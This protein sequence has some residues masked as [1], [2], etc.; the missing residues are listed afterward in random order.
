MV[1]FTT[2]WAAWTSPS[3]RA[4]SDTT[5]VPGWSGSA[6]TLPRTTPSTRRPPLKN[7]LPSMR[8]VAPIRLSMRFCG[9]LS[10][11]NMVLAPLLPSVRSSLHRRVLDHLRLRRT[12]F[13]NA[14]LHARY[15]CLR[16]HPENSVNPLEVLEPQPE[17][18]R[19]GILGSRHRDHSTAAV[20]R[21]AD[22]QFQAP[23]ELLAA[24]R[25]GG[26]QHHPVAVFPWQ[27]VGFYLEAQDGKRRRARGLRGQHAFE[28][29]ELFAQARVFL[30]HGL[31]LLRELELRAALD[32]N[33]AVG[34]IGHRAQAAQFFAQLDEFAA[35]SVHLLLDLAAVEA[36]EA[37]PGVVHPQR[38]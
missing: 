24:A 37:P 3:T 27:H 25:P 2:M 21:Q 10:L 19:V 17:I 13:V 12:G 9:L 31:E 15:P 38:Q 33:L 1:P 23:Q 36:G 22:H 16:I 29:G 26:E 30:L 4:C 7:T 11:R 5:S 8:V 34:C 35:R 6:A 18:G 20:F 28:D 32:R 14:Q